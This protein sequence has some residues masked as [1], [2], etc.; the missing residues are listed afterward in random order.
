MIKK[1][2][3][4]AVLAFVLVVSSCGASGSS[5]SSE[6]PTSTTLSEDQVLQNLA[7]IKRQSCEKVVGDSVA[8]VLTGYGQSNDEGTRTIRQAMFQIGVETR[9]Y[10]AFQRVFA[11]SFQ[12]L[13]T[14]GLARA[15]AE[16]HSL[17]TTECI[18][19]HPIVSTTTSN[20]NQATATIPPPPQPGESAGT[21]SAPT[22]AVKD[23]VGLFSSLL[24]VECTVGAWRSNTLYGSNL[25][26][27]DRAAET[28]LVNTPP[29]STITPAGCIVKSANRT[30]GEYEY[31]DNRILE[32]KYTLDGN[33]TLKFTV[34]EG[35]VGTNPTITAVEIGN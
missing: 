4:F 14:K 33:R 35:G 30:Q 20:S 3:M 15:M 34:A 21:A 32:C 2:W 8:A 31:S 18:R 10:Q 13:P 7:M 27:L 11:A 26:Y 12:S 9:E 23:C 6:L 19:L 16:A 17:T 28:T 5:S 24:A 29:P 25:S 1:C 22:S